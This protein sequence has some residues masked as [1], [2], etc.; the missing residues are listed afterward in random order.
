MRGGVGGKNES[1]RICY[2]FGEEVL[3][4][5][6]RGWKGVGGDERRVGRGGRND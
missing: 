6:V 3:F 4:W 2:L 5:K 1:E